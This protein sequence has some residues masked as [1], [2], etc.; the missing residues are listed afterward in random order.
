MVLVLV[1]EAGH[2]VVAKWCGMRVERFSIF[3]GRP[4]VSFTRG[5]TEYAI[6]WLPLGGY[7][8]ISGMTVGEEIDPRGRAPRVLRRAHLE[9]DR[10]DRRRARRSTS[11]WRSSSS[12]RSSGSACRP[13]SRHHGRRRRQ[14][15][16]AARA[17][18]PAARATAC[19]RWTASRRTATPSGCARSSS[20]ATPG[21]TVTPD[22]SSATARPISRTAQLQLLEDA[23]GQRAH[24]PR[25]RAPA[26]RA[27]LHVRRAAG[28]DRPL[29]AARGPPARAGTSPGSS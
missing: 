27:R 19:W 24:R 4:I 25:H 17:R 3:F 15:D 26:H 1:H 18:R 6:G 29:R 13:H 16:S 14:P 9:E 23:L 21:E 12:R 20:A 28:P 8:K 7:V 10:D 22:R 5:E 11:S 2:M